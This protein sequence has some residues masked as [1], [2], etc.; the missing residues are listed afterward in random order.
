M[1]QHIAVLILSI[2]IAT[3]SS[4][5]Q[6]IMD[7]GWT[8]KQKAR[9]L[10]ESF[11]RFNSSEYSK[12][13]FHK[14]GLQDWQTS[15]DSISQRPLHP[16]TS[17]RISDERLNQYA[18]QTYVIARQYQINSKVHVKSINSHQKATYGALVK[19]RLVSDTDE[20]WTMNSVTECTELMT[21]GY[22]Y[23]WTER[24]GKPTSDTMRPFKIVQPNEE[25]EL[26][27]NE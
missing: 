7:T 14:M 23:I 19:Y 4:F 10:E 17:F 27:E 8:A 6:T 3:T 24:N 18:N 11:N 1:I 13:I 21:I 16:F 2:F 12:E 25:I 5:S 26:V 15:A 20:P 22:Y 9:F